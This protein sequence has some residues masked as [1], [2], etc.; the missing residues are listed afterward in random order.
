MNIL[1]IRSIWIGGTIWTTW[2]KYIYIYIYRKNEFQLIIQLFLGPSLFLE[3]IVQT[4]KKKE[5]VESRRNFRKENSK[6]NILKNIFLPFSYNSISNDLS[7]N[8]Q[9][10]NA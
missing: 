10:F 4:R 5:N 6:Y 1:C 9:R 8:A 2:L 7:Y 3:K